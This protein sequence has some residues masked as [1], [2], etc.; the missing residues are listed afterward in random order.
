MSR[1]PITGVVSVE[2]KAGV[3]LTEWAAEFDSDAPV[4]VEI[5]AYII[6][7]GVRK[8]VQIDSEG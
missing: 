7:H 2:R 3:S 6:A 8:D 5:S 4:I 1:V